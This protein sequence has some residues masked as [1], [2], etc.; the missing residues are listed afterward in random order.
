MNG[1]HI[2]IALFGFII[3]FLTYYTT[4]YSITKSNNISFSYQNASNWYEPSFDDSRWANGGRLFV[5]N[6]T[7]IDIYLRQSFEAESDSAIVTIGGDDCIEELYLN[8]NQFST[9]ECSPDYV[10]KSRNFILTPLNSGRN[11][12][13][14]KIK[15]FQ[16][17][18]W[19]KILETKRDLTWIL[20]GL[21]LLFFIYVWRQNKL[22]SEI[23][24]LLFFI[25]LS[26]GFFY[27]IY[28]SPWNLGIADWDQHTTFNAI[29]YKI[30]ADYRQIPMWEPYLCG[31]EN[32]I[33]NPQS[34]FLTPFFILI[35]LF[36][37]VV[38][39]KLIVVVHAIVGMFGMY[40]LSKYLKLNQISL[41]I[42]AVV[43]LLSGNYSQHIGEGHLFW[44][45]MAYIPWVFLFYLKGVENMF[46]VILSGL[47]SALMLLGGNPY[48]TA[49][50]VIFLT[51]Y[52][53]F[54]VLRRREKGHALKSILILFVYAISL[55]AF[56]AIK[57]VP[58]IEHNIFYP[59]MREWGVY[60][61]NLDLL[62]NSL[63]RMDISPIGSI[64][65]QMAGWWE[66]GSYL[67]WIPLIL[68]L[69]AFF[70]RKNTPL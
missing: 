56:S 13:S 70:S 4:S 43:Y 66:Y 51:L 54:E 45:V 16:G 38:G 1:K 36:G 31:G 21:S 42:P 3:L 23:Y 52:T 50:T 22:D 26:L 60:G 9:A 61:M 30:I 32:V 49:Y 12:L 67:G 27:S 58:I 46:F 69:A 55:F 35:L 19:L 34:Q 33:A 25:L 7:P 59:F 6:E 24:A 47:S 57:L 64:P 10:P 5:S 18:S 11:L 28:K 41:Y 29:P 62:Y 40:L 48:I 14:V 68:A 20:V 63:L 39:V 8:G 17:P 2:C 37:P 53:F 65:G 44:V 15:N